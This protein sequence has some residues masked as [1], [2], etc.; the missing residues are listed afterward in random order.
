DIISWYLYPM[1]L[2]RLFFHNDPP[3]L[4]A[5]VGPKLERVRSFCTTAASHSF[6]FSPF[7]QDR[8]SVDP[9]GQPRRVKK[10]S[11]MSSTVLIA[12]SALFLSVRFRRNFILPAF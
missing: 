1:M 8:R 2:K 11:P 3:I 9:H 6:R 12:P 5:E 4:W 10:C 7:D